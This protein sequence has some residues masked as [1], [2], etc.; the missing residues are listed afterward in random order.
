MPGPIMS[1][2]KRIALHVSGFVVDYLLALPIGCLAALVWANTLP[3]S[4]YRFAHAIAF[5]VNDVGMV[6][7]LALI[8]KEVVEATR[9]VANM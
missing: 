4:Y 8:T 1:R 3:D 9:R 5:A 7:F 6:F 2:H